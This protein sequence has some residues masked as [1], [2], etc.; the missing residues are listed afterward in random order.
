MQIRKSRMNLIES[1]RA[2]FREKKGDDSN[3][4]YRYFS[5]IQV[6]NAFVRLF[7][8]NSFLQRLARNT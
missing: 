4:Y 8:G 7:L 6:K 5:I 3:F 2:S 1:F